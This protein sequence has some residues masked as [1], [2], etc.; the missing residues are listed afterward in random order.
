MGEIEGRNE[1]LKK[2]SCQQHLCVIGFGAK[3]KVIEY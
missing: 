2:N 1:G 3:L